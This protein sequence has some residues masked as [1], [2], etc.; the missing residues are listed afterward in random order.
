MKISI[1]IPTF[2]RKDQ[3]KKCLDSIFCQKI[4]PGLFEIL[5][6][7]DGSVDGTAELLSKMTAEYPQLRHYSQMHKGPAAA[8][9][10]GVKK[11]AAEIIGFVDD[12]CILKENWIDLMI[13]THKENPEIAAVGGLTRAPFESTPNMVSQFLSTGAIKTTYR[14][15]E[16]V[17]FFPTCN[18]SFKKSIF[19]ENNFKETFSLPAG[20]D[21]EFFWSL[22]K[23]GYRFIWEKDAQV[24]HDRN[25]N[26]K[27]FLGQAYAYGRGNFLVQDIHNDQPLLK[28]IKTGNFSFWFSTFLNI[29]KIPRFSYQMS[30]G[31]IK[32]DK[33]NSLIKKIS[34][35]VYFFL[36]KLFYIAGNV[37]EFLRLKSTKVVDRQILALESVIIDITHKCNLSC[38]ICDIWKNAQNEADM[39]LELLKQIL[40]NAAYLKVK[41]IALSGG[42][43]LLREDIFEILDF[44]KKMGIKNLGVLSNGLLVNRYFDKLTPYLID[45]SVSLVL[46]VDSLHAEIHNYVRNSPG[47]WENS[48]EC[49]HKLSELKKVYPD[50][51]FNIITIIMNRN[52]EELAEIAKQMKKLNVNS[53]QFQSILSNNLKMQERNLSEFWIEQDSL[54]L[55]NNAVESIIKL[56]KEYPGFIKNSVENL[57]LMNKYF[58]ADLKAVDARCSSASKTMLICN[59]GLATTCFL[60]YGDFNKENIEDILAGKKI[61]SARKSVEKC[62]WPCLLPCFCDK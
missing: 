39:S 2:N 5:V 48:M 47:V 21:L 1:I 49:L 4:G 14:N 41:E 7:D 22:Y 58:S 23:R 29:I 46:S 57:M 54:G 43:P 18:V 10:L 45:G 26:I 44:S 15:K 12:D 8:R 35:F 51:N 28:E 19:D 9:N 20:E 34:I 33:I 61:V 56:K 24:I 53:L 62:P 11:A 38:R 3:L 55:L 60:P 31:L 6:I 13:K 40:Q 36:H 17:I 50:V 59:Q 42:E 16:E 52:L 37:S 27:S 30:R 32:T 25:D